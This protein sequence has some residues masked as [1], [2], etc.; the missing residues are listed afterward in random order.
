MRKF[1]FTLSVLF[2][3]SSIAFAAVEN[4][5]QKIFTVDSAAY[6][7]IR[8]LYIAEGI[9]RPSTSGPWTAAELRIMLSRI[10][11]NKLTEAERNLY[12]YA[13]RTINEQP[14]FNPNENFGFDIGVDINPE[15]YA[16]AN[17][18]AFTSPDEYATKSGSKWGDYNQPVPFLTLPFETWISSAVYGYT[19]L[20]I[21]SVRQLHSI[22][23]LIAD[24][25]GETIG[26]NYK[27]LFLSHNFPFISPNAFS[28]FDMNFPSRAFGSIGGSW[29][30]F[31][32][33]RD[34]LSWGPGESGNFVIG[35]HIP[36]HNNARLTFFTDP[37][38][39]IFS[40]SAFVHP[41]NYMKADSDGKYY[42]YPSYFQTDQRDGIRM[43]IAHRIEWRMFGRVNFALTEAIMYQNESGSLDPL[44]ISPTAVFHNFY[45]RGYANSILSLEL[46]APIIDH[47]NIY[48][49]FVLD[50]LQMAGEVNIGDDPP[51]ALGY[52]LGTRFSYPLREGTLYG[53]IEAVYTD[54][55][56]YLRDDGTSY[57][58][59]KYGNS[60]V[61]AYPE[62][63]TSEKSGAIL[64]TYAL[65]F[66]GYR[67]GGDA[68]VLNFNT[69]YEKYERWFIEGTL[70]YMVHGATDVL[71][72]WSTDSLLR[73][74]TRSEAQGS[75]DKTAS[76]K[77]AIA[78]YLILTLED[79]YMW[80]RNFNIYTRTDLVSI[81]NKGNI[82]GEYAFD[83]QL[84]VGFKYKV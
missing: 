31:S 59:N 68:I 16:H 71:T 14:R 40:M 34:R 45:I 51:S 77:N 80:S 18:V 21:G 57:D 53:S 75:Y 79:G 32:I 44:V 1:L 33:G 17:D 22:T 11:Y 3:S 39:Y 67:Y 26:Y 69:G 70:M 54:P 37:F 76:A 8:D 49:Q 24:E 55:Y 73:T 4:N 50:E 83:V 15:M 41:M 42:Y 25:G 6:R 78:H 36:Y 7:A 48:F 10:N 28:D 9:A 38:K 63:V 47:W 74:P 23:S 60:F 27:G 29:W 82:E 56:L 2:L 19:S 30:N 20:S 5:W 65:D 66:L 62:F 58:G 35:D 84:T 52:M 61:V 72:R 46:D 12:D 43:F 64:G 81:W 13:E